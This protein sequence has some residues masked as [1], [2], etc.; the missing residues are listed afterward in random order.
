MSQRPCGILPRTGASTRQASSY[1]GI[2][3]RIQEGT[4]YPLVKHENFD[5]L[6][7]E[8]VKEH[9]ATVTVY[10]H[11]LSGAQIMSTQSEEE[12]KVFGVVFP[13]PVNDDSGVAHIL[14]H[15]VL[16][17]SKKYPAKEPFV[18][19]LKSSLKTYL[20]AMTYPDR[21]V[22]PVASPNTQDFYNLVNVYCDAVFNPRLE[23]W[24]LQQEGWHYEIDE[25][26]TTEVA[27]TQSDGSPAEASSN[28]TSNGKS[29]KGVVFNEMKGVY[30]SP[31]SIRSYETE[32][33]LFPDTEYRHS[34]GGDP[35]RIPEL[36]YKEFMAFHAK[37]YHPSNAKVFWYGD[38]DVAK[39][40]EL[41]DS[42]LSEAFLGRPQPTVELP[43]PDI[44]PNTV[45]LQPLLNSPRSVNRAYPC[46]AAG[47]DFAVE[48]VGEGG[49]EVGDGAVSG[50]TAETAGE[51]AVESTIPDVQGAF[52]NLATHAGVADKHD[53]TVNW[54][55]NAH[56][57]DLD[58]TTRMGLG[59]LNHLLMQ[60]QVATVYK[61]LTDSA[62]GSAVIGG[63]Y[64]GMYRD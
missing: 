54:V 28:I 8:D 2:A 62:L 43:H 11:K 21:T 35:L 6:C 20:N 49:V 24:V 63:G 25:A 3:H 5:V 41:T 58:E 51:E 16:C 1:G 13:T 64:D 45:K 18:L 46:C 47:D 53:V 31:E 15:S 39:R 17:G 27:P 40:L 7:H 37:Y 22:Y 23:P 9:S 42:Y 44:G 61:A 36:T 59:V 19:L 14:E 50:E 57:K 32:A 30:S 33:A 38:D 26:A 52:T 10:K 29:L 55:L 4:K 12:E 48:E 34:S 56:P 60:T